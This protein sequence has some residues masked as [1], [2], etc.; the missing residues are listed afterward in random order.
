MP[1][2]RLLLLSVVFFFLSL[3]MIAGVSRAGE[4]DFISDPAVWLAEPA[5]PVVKSW[6]HKLLTP[7][8]VTSGSTDTV[9]I[10]LTSYGTFTGTWHL[11][12]RS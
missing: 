2:I 8:E 5:P 7:D 1:A 4:P 11:I 9:S 6:W 3:L 10:Y 12:V